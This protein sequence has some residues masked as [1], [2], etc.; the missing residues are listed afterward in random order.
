MSDVAALSYS[1]N[2]IIARATLKEASR[3]GNHEPATSF[4]EDT[5]GYLFSVYTRVWFIRHPI[6]KND[7]EKA[8]VLFDWRGPDYQLIRDENILSNE[9]LDWGSLART[10]AY[11]E[12]RLFTSIGTMV[13][14]PNFNFR[15]TPFP[16]LF[17]FIE[18]GLAKSAIPKQMFNYD[19]YINRNPI[20]ITGL[21]LE[22]YTQL[23]KMFSEINLDRVFE[24]YHIYDVG[25][26]IVQTTHNRASSSLDSRIAQAILTIEKNNSDRLLLF[27]GWQM[28][29]RIDRS[30]ANS[31][32]KDDISCTRQ[33]FI[34][35]HVLWERENSV[36]VL[37]C[38]RA[39]LF[40]NN[41]FFSL[42][43]FYSSNYGAKS[44]EQYVLDVTRMGYKEASKDGYLFHRDALFKQWN[45]VE[46]FLLTMTN[47]VVNELQKTAVGTALT[48][49]QRWDKMRDIY[50]NVVNY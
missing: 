42:N 27:N 16:D 22:E 46:K 2:P 15:N 5:L 39:S 21:V 40:N 9:V 17:Y 37:Y 7:P 23:D 33:Y 28:T 4:V 47:G 41:M 30:S 49:E 6:H 13:S 1:G 35:L 10:K 50:E 14:G 36:G 48:R 38:K 29:D 34:P 19:F 44:Y 24:L 3:V 43:V 25:G 11:L 26:P 31:G 18:E 8:L 32:W 20:Y 45:K 12:D